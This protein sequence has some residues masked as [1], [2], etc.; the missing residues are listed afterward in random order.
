MQPGESA[1]VEPI[2]LHRAHF[3]ELRAAE[4]LT[5]GRGSVEPLALGRVLEF[6]GGIPGAPE[7]VAIAWVEG[8]QMEYR[9]LQLD[10]QPCV[11]CTALRATP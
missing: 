4:A 7:Q 5:N 6:T 3:L 11:E 10:R 1:V 9:F 8:P 2:A